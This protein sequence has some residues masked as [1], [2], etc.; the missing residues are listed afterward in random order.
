MQQLQPEGW[1]PAVGY[2]N[3]YVC[4]SGRL[5]ILAGQI[6]WDGAQNFPDC[7]PADDMAAQFAQALR[8]ITAL[9]AE[10]GG[11]PEHIARITGFCTDKQGYIDAR[12][13]I[14]AAWREIMGRNYPAM[15]MIFV[16]DLLEDRA[17]IELEATGVIPL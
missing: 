15:S 16:T 8:N 5:V 10:A 6:G 12:K 1:A 7:D 9:M 14:G 2:A 4:D 11:G 13:A 3:G 17:K